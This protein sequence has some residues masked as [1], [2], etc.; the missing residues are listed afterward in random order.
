MS[1]AKEGLPP[2]LAEGLTNDPDE[3]REQY[4]RSRVADGASAVQ[5]VQNVRYLPGTRVPLPLFLATDDDDTAWLDGSNPNR[6]MRGAIVSHP[7]EVVDAQRSGYICL[8]CL[9]PHTAAFPIACE[10]CGYPMRERQAADFAVE[11]EGETH[12]GPSAALSQYT[13]E[14]DAANEKAAFDRKLREGGSPMKGIRG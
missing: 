8:R 13:Q 4:E 3:D 12:M 5:D 1:E 11:F 6:L 10:L 14:Q 9:E 7:P 2:L